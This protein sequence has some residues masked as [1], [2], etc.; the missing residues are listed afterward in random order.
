ME[1]PLLLSKRRAA[2]VLGVS[3]RTVHALIT[4][5][6]LTVRRIGRRVLVAREDLLH[7]A[8]KDHPTK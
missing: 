1:Q 3:E 6:R 5:Q 8:Q 2:Q 7:F 4:S